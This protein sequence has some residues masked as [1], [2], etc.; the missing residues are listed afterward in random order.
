MMNR[1]TVR[2]LALPR[3]RRVIAVSDIHG[4]LEFFQKLLEKMGFCENDILIMVGDALEK[5]PHSLETLRYLM[6]L[7]ARYTVYP[8]CG[9]CDD[10]VVGFVDG[11]EE[12]PEEFY[13]RFF[14][15][16]GK[17]STLM[18]MGRE[19]GVSEGQLYN[20][21][22]LRSA[23]RDRFRAEFDF[24]R[25]W[26]TILETEKYLFVHGGVLSRAHMED[27]SAW[28]CMKHDDFIHQN[29][30]LDK[31]CVVGHWPVTLYHPDIPAAAPLVL[32]EQKIIS[33]D[34]GCVL[35]LDGQLNAML[36]RDAC[37]EDFS[38]TWYDGLPLVTAL[39]AQAPGADPVNIRWGRNVL[40]VLERG[41]EFSRCRHVESGRVMDILTDYLWERAGV[42]R[43]ED[44]TDY[45]LPVSPG[46]VLSVVR[47]TSRGLLAK[48]SGTTGWYLGRFQ[49][50]GCGKTPEK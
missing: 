27:Q 26:P 36:L 44:S 1:A 43:C 12:L 31:W 49:E 41:G 35:K 46:D 28:Q 18:Q 47:R 30:R 25:T 13:D 33:I 6:D 8:V 7:S 42:V 34:G 39:D 5:G 15:I 40:E 32:P 29:T 14:A 19:A 38:F 20:Q 45:L 37:A 17:Q 3:G 24:L 9:N 22:V 16:W 48:K 4:H 10:L 50:D 23:I 2:R 11:R 21:R